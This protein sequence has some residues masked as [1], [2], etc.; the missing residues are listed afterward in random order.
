MNTVCYNYIMPK[1]TEM[2]M[3]TCIMLYTVQMPYRIL[4]VSVVPW[5]W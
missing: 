4:I 1:Q 5:S 2:H 3:A